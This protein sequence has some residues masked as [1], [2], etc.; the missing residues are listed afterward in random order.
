[1]QRGALAGAQEQRALR[2]PGQQAGIERM[3]EGV[4]GVVA[5][6][7]THPP[8]VSRGA[9]RAGSGEAAALA[10]VQAAQRAEAPVAQ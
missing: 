10:V 5:G 9:R 3:Q 6:V 2:R 1:M 4:E 7:G 8:S